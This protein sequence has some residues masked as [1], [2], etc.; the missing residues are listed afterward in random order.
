MHLALKVGLS[1]EPSPRTV[2]WNT[3]EQPLHAPWASSKHGGGIPGVSTGRKR[4][5]QKGKQGR[6]KERGYKLKINTTVSMFKLN[7]NRVNTLIKR[8]Y[9]NRKIRPSRTRD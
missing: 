5:K 3:H 6:I 4:W 8:G 7:I 9:L 1:D 2:S